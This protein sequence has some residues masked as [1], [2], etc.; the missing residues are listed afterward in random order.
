MRGVP[1]SRNPRPACCRFCSVE[2]SLTGPASLRIE[3]ASTRPLLEP[4]VFVESDPPVS[5]DRPIVTFEQGNRATLIGETGQ[6]ETAESP[7][8]RAR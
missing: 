6:A 1:K 5:G 7:F 8:A 2:R 3:V 4:D